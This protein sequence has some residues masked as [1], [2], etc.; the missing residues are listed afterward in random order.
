M[1]WQELRHIPFYIYIPNTPLQITIVHALAFIKMNQIGGNKQ[2]LNQSTLASLPS[3]GSLFP[4]EVKSY[5]KWGPLHLRLFH[6]HD[7]SMHPAIS[8]HSIP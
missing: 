7:P 3:D 6:Q 1:A 2:R 4:T 5:K 8:P